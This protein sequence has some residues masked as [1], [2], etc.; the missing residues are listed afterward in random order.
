MS[1]Q[2]ATVTFASLRSCAT[3]LMMACSTSEPFPSFSAAVT[4][5]P[6]LP[7]NDDRTCG[8]SSAPT[9]STPS[10]AAGQDGGVTGLPLPGGTS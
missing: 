6:G 5:V 10:R 2:P 3:P 4:S 8:L 9:A 1:G 7:L